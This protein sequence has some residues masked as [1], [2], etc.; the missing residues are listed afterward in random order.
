MQNKETALKNGFF[1]IRES[2]YKNL[3][4]TKHWLWYLIFKFCVIF[5]LFKIFF[6]NNENYVPKNTILSTPSG[7]QPAIGCRPALRRWLLFAKITFFHLFFLKRSIMIW[8][9]C[10][11]MA[12]TEYSDQLLGVCLPESGSKYTA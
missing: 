12:L 3:M 5:T 6:I 8:K 4:T 7:S 2:T 11:K 1:S 10:L 9:K